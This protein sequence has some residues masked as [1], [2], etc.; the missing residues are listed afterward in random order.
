MRTAV[1][2][3]D[4]GGSRVPQCLKKVPQQISVPTRR[5]K[6]SGELRMSAARDDETTSNNDAEKEKE[7]EKKQ[8]DKNNNNDDKNTTGYAPLLSL[9]P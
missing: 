7:R 2:G 3:G 4:G 8:N 9:P 1:R 5:G 6:S